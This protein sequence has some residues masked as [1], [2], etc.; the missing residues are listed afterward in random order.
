ME[1][2]RKM[3]QLSVTSFTHVS[4]FKHAVMR[5]VICAHGFV[6]VDGPDGRLFWCF[7]RRL[8]KS[9]VTST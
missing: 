2:A 7:V 9:D 1:K 4:I 3:I 5:A 6:G 8:S